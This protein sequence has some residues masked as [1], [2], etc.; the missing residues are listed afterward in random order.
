MLKAGA[1]FFASEA[2]SGVVLMVAAVVALVWANVAGD[3]YTATWQAALTIGVAPLAISKPLLLWINDG[4]MAV[5]FFVVGLE[6]KREILHGELASARRAALPVGAALGGML[7]PAALYALVNAGGPGARGWGIPMATDIAFAL[8]A[9][10]LLGSRVAPSL[11]IFLTAVAIADDLGA[12]V[13]IAV[14]LTDD[15]AVGALQASALVLLALA[16]VGRLGVQRAAPYVLLGAVLWVAVLKSGVHATIAG[17]LLAFT[18]PASPSA[19]GRAP[20]LE[21]L[22]HGL[23]PWTAFAIMPIFALANAGV[24][25]SGDIGAALLDPVCVGIILG[26]VIGKQ[27]G[28]GLSCLLLVRLGVATLPSR[29]SWRHLYG[30]AL[31]CGIGFTMSLFIATLALTEPDQLAAA[32]VGIL[33]GSALSGILGYLIL[34]GGARA[35]ASH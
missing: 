28:V 26:L 17:V 15:L 16:V 5:F 6:I 2:S 30:V 3:S 10:A 13:V 35:P 1:R 23:H 19:G 9:L 21:R 25:L 24:R 22:E 27:A 20:L 34:A 33:A 11:R 14:F 31:L 7:V 32:K 29:A 8:G 4:L 12:V 18:I